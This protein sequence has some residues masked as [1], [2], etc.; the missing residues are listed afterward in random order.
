[1]ITVAVG[2]WWLWD[3]VVS[4]EKKVAKGKTVV[5][6]KPVENAVPVVESKGRDVKPRVEPIV[7]NSMFQAHSGV[8][9]SVAFS[10]DGMWIASASDDLTVK[11]WDATSKQS[12]RTFKGHEGNVSTVAF[13]PDSRSSAN[14]Y[15]A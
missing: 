13:S 15:P 5:T 9:N 7:K 10:P 14:V 8:V 12:I 3:S 11:L 6:P 2:Y 1:L 4:P